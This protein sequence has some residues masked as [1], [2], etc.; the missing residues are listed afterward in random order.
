MNQHKLDLVGMLCAE[1][2]ATLSR[3][4]RAKV[5]SAIVTPEGVILGGCNGLASGGDND[6]ETK[7]YLADEGDGVGR[8]ALV[9]KPEVIH[10]EL[11]CLIKAARCSV[12][13]K[14]STLYVTMMPC[15]VCAEMLVQVKIKRVIWRD[16]YRCTKGIDRLIKAGIIVD[17]FKQL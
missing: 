12:S 16:E 8:Y 9:T 2:H 1:A 17:K 10:S 3:G 5:G 13:I 4:V 6:L 11:Q 7:V 14:D 15:I